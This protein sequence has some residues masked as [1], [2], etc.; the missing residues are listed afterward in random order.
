MPDL[1]KSRAADLSWA[2]TTDWPARTAPARK[3]FEE[4]FLKLAE[5]DPKRAAKLREAH[6]KQ[7]RAKSLATRRAKAAARKGD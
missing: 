1:S 5:G 7:M 6:F 3:A 2:N 4:R